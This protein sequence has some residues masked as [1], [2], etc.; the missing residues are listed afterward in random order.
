MV[1]YVQFELPVVNPGRA[2]GRHW[3]WGGRGEGAVESGALEQSLT[4][5]QSFTVLTHTYMAT[6]TSNL[7]HSQGHSAQG[8]LT[9]GG[10]DIL[11]AEQHPS[12]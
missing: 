3:D 6:R 8:V 7:V 11:L 4:W 9:E 10:M 2:I 5:K 1:D 12:L